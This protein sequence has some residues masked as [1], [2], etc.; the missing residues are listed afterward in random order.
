[1]KILLEIYNIS[2]ADQESIEP[3]D[4]LIVAVGHTMYRDMDIKK[5]AEK[6]LYAIL[7]SKKTDMRRLIRNHAQHIERLSRKEYPKLLDKV[8]FFL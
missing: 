3:A 8:R 5:L 1:M 4:A 6:C 2:L 7:A